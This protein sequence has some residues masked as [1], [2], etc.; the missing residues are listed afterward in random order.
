[1]WE[2]RETEEIHGVA[3]SEVFD[4]GKSGT[5]KRFSGAE[6]RRSGDG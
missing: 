1:M 3:R 4:C 2:G 6:A 5:V